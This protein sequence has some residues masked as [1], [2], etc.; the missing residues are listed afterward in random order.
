VIKYI[1]LCWDLFAL[2]QTQRDL[3]RS[4]S[5]IWGCSVS[6]TTRPLARGQTFLNSLV[7]EIPWRSFNCYRKNSRVPL[8]TNCAVR[9]TVPSPER[10]HWCA[11]VMHYRLLINI[12]IASNRVTTLM[13]SILVILYVLEISEKQR[14]LRVQLPRGLNQAGTKS[15][16]G[17]QHL[18]SSTCRNVAV[19]NTPA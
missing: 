10:W 16:Q 6:D 2:P 11:V 15:S 3:S 14:W 12:H 1:L 18:H 13:V 8:H 17:H 19:W 7:R 5:N 9:L 4:F